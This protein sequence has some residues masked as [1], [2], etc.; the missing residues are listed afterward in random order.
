MKITRFLIVTYYKI[1]NHFGINRKCVC[2][3][4]NDTDGYYICGQCEIELF[5]DWADGT[6]GG[7]QFCQYNGFYEC[8][9]PQRRINFQCGVEGLDECPRY[10]EFHEYLF[11]D[12][13]F[14]SV[15]PENIDYNYVYKTIW[16][17]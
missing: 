16:G 14:N 13:G 6:L 11:S 9:H 1:L 5:E 8:E 17:S 7:Q 12:E 4:N 2:C 10:T 3:G 15:I